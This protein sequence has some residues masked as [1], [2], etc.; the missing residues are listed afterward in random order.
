MFDAQY[1]FFSV[2]RGPTNFEDLYQGQPPNIPIILSDSETGKDSQ[3]D[4]SYERLLAQYRQQGGFVP[5]LDAANN[6][7]DPFLIKGMSVPLGSMVTLL[8]PSGPTGTTQDSQAWEYVF[9][10]RLRSTRAYQATGVPYHNKFDGLGQ[11][12]NG[13]YAI[14]PQPLVKFGGIATKRDMIVCAYEPLRYA[15]PEPTN[16]IADQTLWPVKLSTRPVVPVLGNPIFPG[17][18]GQT[19]L[20]KFQQGVV[21]DGL[22][23]LPNHNVH[24]MIALGDELLVLLLSGRGANDPVYNF[25]RDDYYTSLFFGRAGYQLGVPTVA[26]VGEPNKQLGAYL[27]T[28]V[29]PA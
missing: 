26:T 19:A 11:D 17:F 13:E 2:L 9:L 27:A 6:R 20:G 23:T 10:W 14:N 15:Q 25:D 16:T 12:D 5:P 18:G 1:S 3:A 24:R 22:S 28:G 4:E 8:L 29:G 7:V 21:K